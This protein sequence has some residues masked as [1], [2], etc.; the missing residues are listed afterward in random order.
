M[1]MPKINAEFDYRMPGESKPQPRTLLIAAL[2]A[3]RAWF[4]VQ[5]MPHWQEQQ[6]P[7]VQLLLRAKADP[8]TRGGGRT[9]LHAASSADAA[10]VLLLARADINA[11]DDD[12]NTPLQR[13]M[14]ANKE[15]MRVLLNAKAD[16]D[17]QAQHLRA[18]MNS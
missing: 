10:R 12:G 4:R 15:L 18:I 16:A 2:Q 11:L 1:K 5:A 8:N 9:P 17:R 13:P 7:V 3:G 14:S 6:I